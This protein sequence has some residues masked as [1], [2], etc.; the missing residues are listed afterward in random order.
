MRNLL[1]VCFLGCFIGITN[2]AI[3]D[4]SPDTLWIKTYGGIASEYGESVEQCADGGFVVAGETQSFGAGAG[5]VYF[6][7]VDSNG[8]TLWSKTY[9]GSDTDGAYSMK[10]CSNGGFIIVGYTKSFGAGDSDVY[11][12]RVDSLGDTLWTKTYGG[13]DSDGGNS[14]DQCSDKG[15]I[16]TGVTKSFGAGSYD[17]YLIRTDSLGDTLWTKT[18][19]GPDGDGGRSVKQCTDGGFV[20]AGDT[21]SFDVGGGD[22]YIIKVDSIGTT[23]W[24]KIYGENKLDRVYS[25]EQCSDDGFVIIGGTESLGSG[26][27]DVYFIRTD[28]MGILSWAKTYGGLAYDCGCSVKQCSDG[29]FIIT[30]ESDSFTPDYADVYI[31]RTNSDGDV[32]WEKTFGGGLYDT[33]RSVKQCS[34]GGFV[35]VGWTNSSGEGARDIYLIRLKAEQGIEEREV[36]KMNDIKLIACPNLFTQFTTIKYSIGADIDDYPMASLK[37][38]DLTGQLVK[39]LFDSESLTLN[40]QVSVIWDGKDEYDKKVM[41]GVYFYCLKAGKLKATGKLTKII[42]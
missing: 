16:I 3:A 10:Q 14:V 20:I 38:Y 5:D 35:I 42:R 24:T 8:D 9:G 32:L 4:E 26:S 11:L 13:N 36:L 12:L 29:G 15:F 2:L 31:I 18:Y 19:G 25:I 37:I 7:K 30:G 40:S 21:Y 17:I 33:G 41:S 39:T 27:S 34:D 22:I 23:L 1:M 6:M 28:S